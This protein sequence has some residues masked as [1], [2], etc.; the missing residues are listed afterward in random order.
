M[1]TNYML[2]MTEVIENSLWFH[3]H[4]NTSGKFHI[5]LQLYE[6]MHNSDYLINANMQQYQ[7]YNKI[8][9]SLV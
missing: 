7:T 9:N 4:N 8:F 2:V 5:I 3:F 6:T 1:M